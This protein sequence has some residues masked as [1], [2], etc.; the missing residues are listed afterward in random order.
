LTISALLVDGMMIKWR[1][2]CCSSLC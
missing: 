2:C 1:F